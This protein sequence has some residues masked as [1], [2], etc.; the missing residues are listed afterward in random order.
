VPDSALIASQIAQNLRR[1]R[2]GRGFSLDSLA[3]RSGVSRGM[4]IGIEQE[5]TNPTVWTLVRVADALWVSVSELIETV[6]PA[7][8]RVVRAGEANRLWHT[9]AGSHATLLVGSGPAPLE[10]WDWHLRPGD[11]YRT[12]AHVAGVRE[13]ITVISGRTAL[14]VGDETHELD[15]GDSAMYP[16]DL[17]HAHACLGEEPCRFIMAVSVPAPPS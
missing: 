13:L 2:T 11:R 4:L 8:V 6:S 10:L 17:P 16:G 3:A 15:P 5:R 7:S 14:T 1:L 9:D 12:E